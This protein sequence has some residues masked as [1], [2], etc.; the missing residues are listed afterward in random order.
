MSIEDRLQSYDDRHRSVVP[1]DLDAVMARGRERQRNSRIA[2]GVLAVAIVVGGFVGVTAL[3]NET[4]PGEIETVDVPEAVNTIPVPV[5]EETT[6]DRDPEPDNDTDENSAPA[7]ELPAVIEPL[8]I[9]ASATSVPEPPELTQVAFG[10]YA[11]HDGALMGVVWHESQTF[12][13]RIATSDG[14]AWTVDGLGSEDRDF[15]WVDLGSAGDQVVS[16]VRDFEG[17]DDGTVFR[18]GTSDT[19]EVWEWSEAFS[20]GYSET[21]QLDESGVRVLAGD[22][23]VFGPVGGPYTVRSIKPQPL[24]N[25]ASRLVGNDV[26]SVADD[27]S[28]LWRL[29][30]AGQWEPIEIDLPIGVVWRQA[31]SGRDLL[32]SIDGSSLVI[33][34]LGVGGVGESVTSFDLSAY[35]PGID[36]VA[37]RVHSTVDG[38]DVLNLIGLDGDVELLV[39]WSGETVAVADLRTLDGRERFYEILGVAGE[40]VVL[41]TDEPTSEVVAIALPTR[42]E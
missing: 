6:P 12:Y 33:D 24:L 15:Q 30:E 3:L 31:S 11:A 13:R 38:W 5:P 32:A 18:I 41:H 22:N 25:A 34:E 16:V 36:W 26:W 23:L 37:P 40:H 39:M 10:S 27:R 28:A 29:S 19:G 20:L 4:V 2:G 42:S 14:E 8:F 1:G 21:A 9:D 17:S 35:L 7:V